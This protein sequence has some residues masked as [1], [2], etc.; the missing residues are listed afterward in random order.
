MSGIFG[1]TGSAK[2]ITDTTN[3]KVTSLLTT[4]PKSLANASALRIAYDA[5]AVATAQNNLSQLNLKDI[6]NL[7]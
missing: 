6:P 1:L 4:A 5:E 7:H 2:N 3:N